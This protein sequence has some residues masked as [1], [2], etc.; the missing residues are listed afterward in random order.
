MRTH[1]YF[2]NNQSI[3]KKEF[4]SRVPNDWM[5]NLDEYGNYSHGYYSAKAL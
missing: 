5:E 2:Y 1:N 3:S 4:E